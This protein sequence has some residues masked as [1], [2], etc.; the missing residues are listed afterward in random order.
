MVFISF[1]RLNFKSLSGLTVREIYK[2]M[3]EVDPA[4]P[5]Q[6]TLQRGSPG[7]RGVFFLTQGLGANISKTY[8][9]LLKYGYP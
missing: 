9:G 8:G 6:V 4:T 7:P 5:G 1:S 3:D 2:R